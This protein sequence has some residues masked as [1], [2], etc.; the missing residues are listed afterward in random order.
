MNHFRPKSTHSFVVCMDALQLPLGRLKVP[1]EPNYHTDREMLMFPC[2]PNFWEALILTRGTLVI[3]KVDKC[4]SFHLLWLHWFSYGD[5]GI[6]KGS[7]RIG[8]SLF[9]NL[10][11]TFHSIT[12][13]HTHARARN[14]KNCDLSTEIF[15]TKGPQ[16]FELISF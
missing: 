13:C 3:A 5:V 7:L 8:R 2:F 11:S 16:K 12:L 10:N 14:S 4:F 15:H 9:T 1:Q 6:C